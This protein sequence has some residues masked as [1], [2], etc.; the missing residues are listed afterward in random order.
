MEAACVT[1]PV[2]AINPQLLGLGDTVD[3]TKRGFINVGDLGT[4]P[5]VLLEHDV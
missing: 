1:L 3:P 4:D 5:H 2:K